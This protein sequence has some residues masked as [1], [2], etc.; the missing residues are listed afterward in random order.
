M[1]KKFLILFFVIGFGFAFDAFSQTRTRTHYGRGNGFTFSQDAK[2]RIRLGCPN[3]LK[4]ANRFSKDMKTKGASNIESEII[5]MCSVNSIELEKGDLGPW[6]KFVHALEKVFKQFRNLIYLA[7]IFMLLWIIVKAMYEGDMKWMHIGMMVL[8]ITMLSFAEVFLDI[9]TNRV[10]IDDI[11]NSE[12]Y[13]DCREPDR[14]LYICSVDTDGAVDKESV[15]LYDVN[16][17]A[18]K[19]KVFKGLY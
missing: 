2:E 19:T 16:H 10:T 6:K 9:A 17:K 4:R 18:T 12:I 13:V 11:R 14:G 8:G 3:V 5:Y 15:Y 1:F 7:A